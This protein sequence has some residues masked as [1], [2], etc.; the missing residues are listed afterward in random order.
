MTAN[1]TLALP[2]MLASGIAAAVSKQLSY[3]S[4]YT[5]KLLRRGIDIGSPRTATVLQTLTVSDV[6]QPVPEIDGHALLH[7]ATRDH[8]PR[9]DLDHQQWEKLIGPVT[10]IR[11]PQEL[12][13]DETLEQ[14]LRQLTLYGRA[15]LPVMS[16]DREHLLG[17]IT[18]HNVLHALVQSVQQSEQRIEQG[19]LAAD[20]A[21]TDPNALAHT[22]STPLD[23]YEILELTVA[24]DSPALGRRL[25]QLA[26]PAGCRIVAVTERH[27]LVPMHPDTTLTP[28]ERIILLAPTASPPADQNDHTARSKAGI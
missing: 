7:P 5:T 12:F 13:S 19:A 15:G 8:H 9:P 25:E 24:A 20:F 26:L 17:W 27:E 11:E 16:A 18:R 28:G 10:D 2:I 21:A 14:A 6:M 23:G 22:P 4:V 3:G 1:F